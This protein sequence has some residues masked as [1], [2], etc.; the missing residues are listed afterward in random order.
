M[1][2]LS[3]NI[4]IVSPVDPMFLSSICNRIKK[5][6]M[7]PIEYECESCGLK[8]D[9]SLMNLHKDFLIC[10]RCVEEKK[11]DKTTISLSWVDDDKR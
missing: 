9:F 5:G 3:R 7:L 11:M 4:T 1:K 2:Y 10:N 8:Y 6:M